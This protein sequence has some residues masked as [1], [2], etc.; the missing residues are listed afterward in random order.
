MN[1]WHSPIHHDP[2]KEG[3]VFDPFQMSRIKEGILG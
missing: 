1:S 2:C 3:I